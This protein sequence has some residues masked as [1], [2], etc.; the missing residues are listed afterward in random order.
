MLSP[1]PGGL[2]I[3]GQEPLVGGRRGSTPPPL[4]VLTTASSATPNVA[5]PLT[6]PQGAAAF[7]SQGPSLPFTPQGSS[8]GQEAAPAFPG[9]VSLE[10]HLPNG[11]EAARAGESPRGHTALEKAVAP[12]GLGTPPH[13]SLLLAQPRGYPL[14]QEPP[15]PLPTP[16]C[17]PTS[18]QALA[19]GT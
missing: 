18:D 13:S 15:N 17:P 16:H 19:P 10:T 2:V 12:G 5:H 7:A 4:A 6:S 1:P 11:H 3:G 14:L 8:V 9:Q